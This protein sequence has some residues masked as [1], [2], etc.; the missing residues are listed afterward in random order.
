[1]ATPIL[2]GRRHFLVDAHALSTVTG[3]WIQAKLEPQ[4]NRIHVHPGDG[5]TEDCVLVGIFAAH[6]QT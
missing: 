6:L 3:R 2:P 1:L 5:E 4:R